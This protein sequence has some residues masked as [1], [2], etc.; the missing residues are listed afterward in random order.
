MQIR[1]F[2]KNEYIFS[3]G[4]RFLHVLLSFF[5][6]IFVARFLGVSLKG[7]SAYVQSI[8]SIG[9]IMITFGVHQAYPYFRKKY[10]KEEILKNYMTAIYML[11]GSYFLIA[12]LLDVFIVHQIELKAA[13]LLSPL[14]G[15]SN[16]VSYVSLIENPNSR[17]I[18]W[19]IIYFMEVV[20]TGILFF[21]TRSNI[22]WAFA[23]LG[24]GPIIKSIVFS[25]L[26]R[27]PPHFSTRLSW[28]Y[29]EL[30]KYGFFPM[31]SLLM[32]TLNYRIDILMLK[33]YPFI[34]EALIGIYSVGI[35]ISEKIVLIP[36]TLQGIL[37]S[38]LA[39]GAQESE[40]VRICRLSFYASLVFCFVALVFGEVVIQFMY[41]IDYSGAYD[42]VVISAVGAVMIGYF[43]LISQYNIVNKKQVKNVI[44]LS[45][46]VV[47][48][49]IC[50]LI[51]IPI[52][53][54]S[55]AA[56]ATCIGHLVCGIVFLVWFSRVAKCSLAKMI[57][58]QKEDIQYVRNLICR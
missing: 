37:A 52:L 20:I 18:W 17:N 43:K 6:S 51:F 8:A 10:E 56:L 40:V 32:T 15:Y 47:I 48:N 5:Q 16:V 42:V 9:S 4:T 3:V 22:Y 27:V 35:T 21:T 24:F 23:I 38:R 2:L 11:F 36:D 19:L 57:I 54:I 34:T 31:L 55:G 13:I 7:T 14:M 58:L 1:K 28:M 12:V 45:I 49:I 44:M 26:I 30:F 29:K 33:R 41:G 53:G 46:S 50:N 39:K 25:I